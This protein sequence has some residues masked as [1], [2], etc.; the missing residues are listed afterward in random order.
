MDEFKI[1]REEIDGV[2]ILNLDG[3]LDAHTSVELEKAFEE[4]KK[5][6]NFKVIV[7]FSR[8]TYISSAGLGVFMAFIEDMRS[9]K[10]DIKLS[11]MSEKIYNIFDMLGFPVLFEIYKDQ[12]TALKKFNESEN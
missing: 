3:F 12:D 7:N 6:S 4:L 1:I 5:E 8:L 9:N 11:E 2:S 10:G